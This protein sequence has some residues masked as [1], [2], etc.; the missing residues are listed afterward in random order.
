VRSE[1]VQCANHVHT[2][3]YNIRG[4]LQCTQHTLLLSTNGTPS[5]HMEMVWQ[6]Q[7]QHLPAPAAHLN[8]EA[9]SS[10]TAMLLHI[11]AR[12]FPLHNAAALQSAEVLPSVT[13]SYSTCNVPAA[14]T[15][16][17][18]AALPP[19]TACCSCL[20]Q[21]QPAWSSCHTP[22][23]AAEL[24]PSTSNTAGRR[25]VLQLHYYC[26][27]QVQLSAAWL[28]NTSSSCTCAK[29]SAVLQLSLHVADAALCRLV[30]RH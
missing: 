20:R 11:A 30:V 15:C 26:M 24:A 1:Y 6:Q 28:D 19:R 29:R 21:Q 23:P 27:L 4:Q 16:C 7:V 13:H 5:T 8:H 2:F 22:P 17:A 12:A 18:T 9:T 3:V 14:S 25:A 10:Q